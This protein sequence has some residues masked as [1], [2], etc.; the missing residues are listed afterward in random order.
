MI[1]VL[2]GNGNQFSE[3]LIYAGGGISLAP[4]TNDD[5]T[6]PSIS[7]VTSV[8]NLTTI[9]YSFTAANHTGD[10][11][12]EFLASGVNGQSPAFLFLGQTRVTNVAA[13][14]VVSGTAT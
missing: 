9:N 3:N 7:S 5:Q 12:V 11:L 1:H 2:L 14:S 4:G 8:P 10:Y 13:N 6:A